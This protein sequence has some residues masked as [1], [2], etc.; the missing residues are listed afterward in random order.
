MSDIKPGWDI[1]ALTQ[2]EISDLWPDVWYKGECC[3]DFYGY[4]A[5]ARAIEHHITKANQE[6]YMGYDPDSDRFFMGFDT[7]PSEGEGWQNI[8]SWQYNQE[9]GVYDVKPVGSCAR[10]MY[11]C[12]GALAELHDRYPNLLDLRLD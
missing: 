4:D 10:L 9:Y 12:Y 2:E 6:C 7:W 8:I 5:I 3:F 11:G 1:R